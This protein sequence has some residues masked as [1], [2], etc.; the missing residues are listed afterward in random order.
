MQ[1]QCHFTAEVNEFVRFT[2][3]ITPPL[4]LHP[5]LLLLHRCALFGYIRWRGFLHTAFD[6]AQVMLRRTMSKPMSICVHVT[7][8]LR[9][10]A[11]PPYHS[12]VT[13]P[14]ERK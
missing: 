13:L 3:M 11:S 6:V 14:Y 2:W 8:H 12:A 9:M 7:F 10:R 4:P 1:V 5:I